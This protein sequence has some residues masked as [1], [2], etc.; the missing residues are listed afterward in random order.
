M[1]IFSNKIKNH[2]LSEWY[3]NHQ[4]LRIFVS[5]G[6]F[7]NI[8]ETL[9]NL[10][11]AI[12]SLV[13]NPRRKGNI[14]VGVYYN[15][16]NFLRYSIYAVSNFIAEVTESVFNGINAITNSNEAD[17]INKLANVNQTGLKTI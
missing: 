2:Y 12:R 7:G 16:Y 14:V 1:K 4:L 9:S 5:I 8:H 6:V 17:Q 15:I 11:S 3:S 10:K 13:E